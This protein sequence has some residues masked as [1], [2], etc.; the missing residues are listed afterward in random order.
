M[1]HD[2]FNRLGRVLQGRMSKVAETDAV[3][4]FGT[5]KGNLALVPDGYEDIIVPKGDYSVLI[6]GRKWTPSSGDRVVIAWVGSEI[7]VLGKLGG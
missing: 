1:A 3:I 6:N 4:D 5:I 2:G 7:V